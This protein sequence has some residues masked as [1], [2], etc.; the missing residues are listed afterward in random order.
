L[1]NHR[2]RP[3]LVEKARTK[4]QKAEDAR[5]GIVSPE[6]EPLAPPPNWRGL[7]TTGNVKLLALLI[8]FQDYPPTNTQSYIHSNLFGSGDSTRFPYES[9]SP[10]YTRSS[11]GQL[12]ITGNTLGWYTTAYPRSEVP[13]T[14]A[15]RENL[16]KE[17]LNYYNSLGHDFT[18]YD[19]D[20]DGDIDY[21]IVIWTGPD[22]GWANFWWGMYLSYFDSSYAIDGKTIDSYSWQW[23]SR[24]VDGAF[25]PRVAIHET[26]HALGCLTT[27][28]TT[29][30]FVPR[31]VS[32][33]WT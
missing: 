15:G 25:S 20:G 24:P 30:R 10:Y 6:E 4:L 18:Q 33:G 11:Y 1:G 2:F 5:T 13:L 29:A 27:T 28:T 17:A 3:E 14:S 31:E 22:N 19:N 23:E 9:L 26:G 16:I 12:S 7:R 32:G 21:L 8:A